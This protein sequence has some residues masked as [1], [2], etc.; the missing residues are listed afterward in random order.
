MKNYS[1]RNPRGGMIMFKKMYKKMYKKSIAVILAAAL[2]MSLAACG[3]KSKDSDS[4]SAESVTA[5][6]ETG[7]DEEKSVESAASAEAETEAESE[8]KKEAKTVEASTASGGALAVTDLFTER[9]LTQEA[10]LSD[11]QTLK[12]ESGKDTT[13][14]AA[15]VY[16]ITGSAENA[17]VI[18]DAGDDD[19]VQLVLDGVTIT[20]SDSPAIYV[21]NADKVFVTTTDSTS[22]LTVNGTF[23]ADGD[24]NTDAVIFS[25]DD[26]T[27]N[28]EGTLV[29][30]S[31]DNG[32]SGKDD[33]KITGG[34]IEISCTDAAVEANDS[35]RIAD[36]IITINACND[37]LHAENDDDDSLG[38]IY[39]C[40]GSLAINAE[41]DG[42][43]GT[44]VVQ[45]DGGDLDIIAAEG[46]EGTYVQVNGG[47]VDI[48]ASDDGINA[49][50]KSSAYSIA[51]EFNGGE[52]TIDMAQG[53]TDG[54]DSNGNL[55]ITGGT[56]SV[57]GQSAFDYDGELSW[58]GGTILVN[59]EE[60]TEIESQMF[61]PGGGMGGPGGGKFE[62]EGGREGLP[63]D[64]QF[65]ENFDGEMPQKPS[66]RKQK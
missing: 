36:G 61:G 9:D 48:S 37:G 50:N 45:I 34:T 27:L 10:D 1:K 8:A 40:G 56:V 26:L 59:G 65:P 7:T 3:G 21:K 35:I 19:K 54:V 22:T 15:G 33:L 39:I 55:I 46:I 18:V 66:E 16:V 28:G 23:T 30:S 58:T 24:T 31:T 62:G 64:G 60:V 52:V 42:I 47:T 49:A 6:A 43:H 11:A 44:T 25:K 53:D 57:N 14:S 63:A 51:A 32:I 2:S 29:I 13:I 4:G 5:A 20:N 38:Y 41:D 12:L 17:T